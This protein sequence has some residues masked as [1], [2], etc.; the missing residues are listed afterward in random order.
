M[1]LIKLGTD[2]VCIIK[3]FFSKLINQTF[4]IK[5]SFLNK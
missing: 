1:V 2:A 5:I 4:K 3:Y